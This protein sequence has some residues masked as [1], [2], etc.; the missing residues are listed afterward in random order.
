MKVIRYFKETRREMDHVSWPTRKQ[1]VVF[2][3]LII[4]L[5]LV[6]AAYLGLLDLLFTRIIALFI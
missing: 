2:T 4:V 5:S 1:T 6:M 3:V